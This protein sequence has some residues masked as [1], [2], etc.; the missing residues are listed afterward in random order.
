MISPIIWKKLTN[1]EQF[2]VLQRPAQEN[3]A[4]FQLALKTIIESVR[5]EGDAACKQY[6]AQ[7]DG[8]KL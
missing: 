1:Q 5:I 4:D 6:T 3:S 8:V 7:F 2:A